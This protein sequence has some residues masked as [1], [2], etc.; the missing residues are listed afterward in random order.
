MIITL[1]TSNKKN[2]TALLKLKNQIILMIPGPAGKLDLQ[3]ASFVKPCLFR[4]Y[5]L[6]AFTPLCVSVSSQTLEVGLYGG[7]SYYIGDL[8]PGKHFINSQL[9]YGLSARYNIDTRWAVKINGYRGKITGSSS[10]TGFLP[11]NQLNFES[12]ITDISAEVEFNFMSYFTGSHKDFFSPYI[13]TGISL[14]FYDPMANGLSLR[15]LGTEGQNIG[16]QGR[17]PY[18]NSGI[19]IPFGLGVKLSLARNL[20]MTVFWEMHKTFTDYL[21]DVSTTYYLNSSKINASDPAEVL[22]DPSLSHQ[23]LME[24]GNPNTRDWYSFSGL[25]LTYKFNLHGRKKCRDTKFM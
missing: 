10:A 5:L 24:R 9:A 7:A 4:I 14:F 20:G 15:S 12:T 11:G 16:F 6:L 23:P 19:G 21:D 22:S 1:L 3:E 17:Q 2:K 8:N 13:Y 18:G 25:T